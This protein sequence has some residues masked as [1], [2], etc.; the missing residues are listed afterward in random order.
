MKRS[1]Q[2]GFT[3]IELMIVVAIIGILAAVA[4]PAYQDYT[5]RA[6][7]SEAILAGSSCRTSITETIQAASSGTQISANGWG[8]E[9]TNSA[10]GTKYVETVTT[11]A[12]AAGTGGV[13]VTILTRGIATGANGNIRL[14]P[15]AAES[16]NFS[17]CSQPE[18][19]GRVHS[20][21]CGPGA[22]TP[23]LAK[24][25]PGSCRAT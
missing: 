25:L 2:K 13:E 15:C 6:K 7:I 17:S 10:S 23:V 24:F 19:G 1:V 5:A 3:L 4:L 12:A 11:S 8:C 21:L 14:K 22:T 9:I 16:A 20:W 18:F